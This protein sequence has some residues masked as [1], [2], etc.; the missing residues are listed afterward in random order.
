MT[1]T[2]SA[3]AERQLERRAI[4]KSAVLRHVEEVSGNVAATCRY[5]GIS[6]Q[7]YYGW[8]KRYEEEGVEGLRDR[9]SAPHF[10]RTATNIEVVEK[11][12]WLR[13]HYQESD[14]KRSGSRDS[15]R[16]FWHAWCFR[17]FRVSR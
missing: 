2:I 10:A 5:Y 14:S 9:S 4:H 6:R 12:H 17:S 11:I 8:L 7:A 13:L 16:A 3:S 15:P 1:S